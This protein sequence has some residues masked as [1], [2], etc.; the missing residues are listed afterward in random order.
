MSHVM[1]M[2]QMSISVVPSHAI[3]YFL[4]DISVPVH[5]VD[6]KLEMETPIQLSNIKLARRSAAVDTGLAI[7]TVGRNATMAQTVAYARL[8]AR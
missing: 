7:T 3:T 4:V 6:A 1:L 8:N 5:A 2:S